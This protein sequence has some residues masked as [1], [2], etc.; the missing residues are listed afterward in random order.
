MITVAVNSYFGMAAAFCVGD[1]IS[2]SKK[3]TVETIT[4]AHTSRTD[5]LT[6]TMARL[7][8][9]RFNRQ[10][11]GW[12]VVAIWERWGRRRRMEI[13]ERQQ[14]VGL[15]ETQ[16]AQEIALLLLITCGRKPYS[17][18]IV[19]RRKLR[20]YRCSHMTLSL[21]TKKCSTCRQMALFWMVWW[22]DTPRQGWGR[23][24]HGWQDVENGTNL[25][26]DAAFTF[27][28]YTIIVAISVSPK[29]VWHLFTYF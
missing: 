14:M 20:Q 21:K 16:R 3:P 17:R 28:F 12:S 1:D 11:R 25:N 4:M 19:I 27:D 18:Q 2:D 8:L 9:A 24:G 6:V 7:S 29:L 26:N 15:G 22:C 5:C 23:G 10:H 13:K